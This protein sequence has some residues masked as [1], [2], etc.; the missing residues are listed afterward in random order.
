[1]IFAAVMMV[2]ARIAWA[3]ESATCGNAIERVKARQA[4][5]NLQFDQELENNKL[6]L[7]QQRRSRI[8]SLN[9]RAKLANDLLNPLSNSD[10]Q[11]SSYPLNVQFDFSHLTMMQDKAA[12]TFIVETLMPRVKVYLER[13]F[14]LKHPPVEGVNAFYANCYEVTFSKSFNYSGGLGILV[15]AQTSPEE[16]V[17]YVA[18]SMVCKRDAVTYRPLLGQINFNPGQLEPASFNTMFETTIHEVF[19]LMGFS[20]DSF[21]YFV[22]DS[23]QLLNQS[24]AFKLSADRGKIVGIKTAT[25]MKEATH[26]YNC[27]EIDHLPLEDE[28]SSGS[29]FSHWERTQFLDEVMT[30]SSVA[31][32]K[33]SVFTLSLLQDSGWYLVDFSFKEDYTYL[34]NSQCNFDNSNYTCSNLIEQVCSFDY[35]SQGFCF[36]DSFNNGLMRPFS[37]KGGNCASSARAAGKTRFFQNYGSRSFCFEASLAQQD[38]G[39]VYTMDG[40]A[41]FEALCFHDAA[42]KTV[43][44]TVDGQHYY[45][46]ED[47]QTVSIQT[48]TFQAD[49]RCPFIDRFCNSDYGCSD[50]CQETGRCLDCGV[51]YTYN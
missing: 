37:N 51:C 7:E 1:M 46:T 36:F 5:I 24:A 17:D 33:I 31:N 9:D 22:D 41:C 6:M 39:V 42:N 12:R 23:L 43:R 14:K 47:L 18:Y 20:G 40:P 27:S 11:P 10:D 30:A 44:F 26:Y 35:K 49:I 16:E 25:V 38:G 50:Y 34:K 3:H 29:A 15:T 32:S 2:L 45:C 19:H 8:D 48:A 13:V 21:K 28:G 4:E